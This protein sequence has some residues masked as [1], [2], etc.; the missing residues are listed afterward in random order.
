VWPSSIEELV[1]LQ[2]RLGAE[3]PEPWQPPA[4][5]PTVAGCFV[6]FPSDDPGR[7]CAVPPGNPD[8]R[9]RPSCRETAW[10]GAALLEPGG[11]PETVAIEGATGG[12]YRPGLLALR[13]GPALEQAVDRLPARPDVLLVDATGRDHPRRAGLAF[14]LG[15]VLDVPTIGVT[16]R[17]LLAEGEWP[18][19]ARGAS[20]PLRVGDKVV[21]AW[22]RVQ[23]RARPI[24]VHAAWRTDA[25]TAVEVV[26]AVARKVRT[27]EPLRQARRV[28]RL[29]RADALATS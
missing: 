25:D 27:P 3:E 28:A 11:R 10:A 29:A 15:R 18:D 20:S 5:P 2:Q 24:A 7:G 17:T 14:H 26:M 4:L 8:P 1:A 6:C 12:A 13:A 19:E 16:H 21:G 23:P 9:D 22:L